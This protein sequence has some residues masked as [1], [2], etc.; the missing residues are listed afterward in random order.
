M[1]PFAIYLLLMCGLLCSLTKTDAQTGSIFSATYKTSVLKNSV[2]Y[3]LKDLERKNIIVEYSSGHFDTGAIIK[4]HSNEM[5]V[6]RLLRQLFTG[7]N[8]R[9]AQQ[10][11]KILIIPSKQVLNED[12]FPEEYSVFGFVKD[13]ETGEPLPF[14]LVFEPASKK[15]TE[16]DQNGFYT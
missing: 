5:N 2:G 12:F 3:Y 16:A 9:I 15:Y 13:A 14:A 11:N 1:R 4:L 10:Q 8:V 6:G 7:Q